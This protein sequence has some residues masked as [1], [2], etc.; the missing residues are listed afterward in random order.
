MPDAE[1]LADSER[2]ALLPGE[3]HRHAF[4]RKTV[5][6]LEPARLVEFTVS[7][8]IGLGHYSDN[9]PAS[10]YHGAVVQ[11][12]AEAHRSTEDHGAVHAG[13]EPQQVGAGLL[14]RICQSLLPEKIGAGVAR[15]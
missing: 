5:G 2:D 12:P 15:D 4:F 10:G 14:G 13:G 6:R 7:G 9:P 1:Q 3:F 11:S 8:E